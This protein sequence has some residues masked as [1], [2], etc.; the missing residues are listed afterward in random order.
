[1]VAIKRRTVTILNKLS[2]THVEKSRDFELEKR[3]DE[4][5]IWD[6]G[7]LGSVRSWTNI[8]DDDA[9]NSMT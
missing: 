2:R 8:D 7:D 5:L 9:S 6:F 3:W 1:M 4:V